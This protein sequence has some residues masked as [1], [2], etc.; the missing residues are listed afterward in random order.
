MQNVERRAKKAGCSEGQLV[1]QVF[2]AALNQHFGKITTFL[3]RFSHKDRSELASG[4]SIPEIMK[5]P[6][7]GGLVPYA[8]SEYEAVFD[9]DQQLLEMA[10]WPGKTLSEGSGR[11]RVWKFIKEQNALGR[12]VFA[13]A[14]FDDLGEGVDAHYLIKVMTG[15]QNLYRETL[16]VGG[17]KK[18]STIRLVANPNV[19]IVP[20]GKRRSTV[21]NAAKNVVAAPEFA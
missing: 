8:G 20:R 14:D 11:W 13:Y 1:Q 4:L 16:V 7:A 2:Q 15:Y 12:T 3:D 17:G 5:T 18:P 19:I 10:D 6:S 9:L 21:V